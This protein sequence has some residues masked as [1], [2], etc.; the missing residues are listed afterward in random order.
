MINYVWYN[1]KIY[2]FKGSV[3][4]REKQSD[5]AEKIINNITEMQKKKRLRNILI[6]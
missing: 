1:M 2:I 4:L 3:Y 5:M 6:N